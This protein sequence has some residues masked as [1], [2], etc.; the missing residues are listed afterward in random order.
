MQIIQSTKQQL[1]T[2]QE[3]AYKIWPHTYGQILSK[4]QLE[5]M[6]SNFYSIESLE[7]QFENGHVFLF[8]END[9]QYLGFAAYETDCKEKGKTK[10]HKIYVMPNTQGKG[11]GKFLLNEVEKRTK[12]AENKYLFL[13]V[14]K[15]N[16]AI[17]FY[18]KQGFVKIADEIID[19]GQGYV[20]D[21]YVMEKI[22]K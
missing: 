19:I 17:N 22:I 3:L 8:V 11:I 16:N 18:K 9:G 21:D 1:K 6:L 15:Y 14:N 2:V 20:M 7:N 10:L 5:Y 4:E 13:N 12:N